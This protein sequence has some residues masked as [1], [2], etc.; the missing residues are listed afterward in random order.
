[1]VRFGITRASGILLAFGGW[2][3][4]VSKR[5][6]NRT[7]GLHA[8]EGIFFKRLEGQVLPSELVKR[9]V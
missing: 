5:E 3:A 8:R 7:Y 4:T 6:S 2:S 1:V 9:G